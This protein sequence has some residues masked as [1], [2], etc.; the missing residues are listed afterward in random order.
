MSKTLYTMAIGL[1]LLVGSTW[2]QETAEE[3]PKTGWKNELVGGVNLSQSS[4]DNWSQ[5]GED[6]LAWQININ[7]K[8]ENDQEKTNWINS[9]KL[10]FGHVK[11]G[12]QGSKKSV[13]EI[14][15]ESVL[16]YKTGLFSPYAAATG[17]TQLT[18]GYDYSLDPRVQ[19]SDLFDPAYLT[20][21]AGIQYKPSEII[22][23]RLGAALKETLTRNHPRYS[24]D[25][26]TPD[27]L[28]KTRVEFGAES[29]TD[30]EKK[31]AENI[32]LTSKLELFSNLQ[33]AKEIDVRWDTIFTSKISKF[34]DVNFNVQLFY[35]S[36][37]SKK[38]QLK[39][40][41]AL[42]LSYNFME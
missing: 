40:A 25:P 30:L 22:K 38:R 3:A 39:Q 18:A 35:D 24:D 11:I 23:T 41:L 1:L 15:M 4:F 36:D 34:I 12:D 26:D 9:G 28:E 19:V 21:S 14:R 31:L 37:I 10:S 32:Q 5:G 42:G 2:A 16:T 17:Q 33:S 29:V 20:Q 13:D 6:N 7:A 8:F 27:T